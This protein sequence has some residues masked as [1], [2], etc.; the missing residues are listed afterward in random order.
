MTQEILKNCFNSLALSY[1]KKNKTD[2]KTARLAVSKLIRVNQSKK[3]WMGRSITNFD[4]SLFYLKD[5][6]EIYELRK[7]HNRK[8]NKTVSTYVDIEKFKDSLRKVKI[9]YNF[10]QEKIK[11]PVITYKLFN[12]AKEVYN[13]LLIGKN[14][15]IHVIAEQHKEGKFLYT[16]S[17]TIKG[18]VNPKFLTK[19]KELVFTDIAGVATAIDL[20][21]KDDFRECLYINNKNINIFKGYIHIPTK[22]H[23]KSIDEIK[24]L[25]RKREDLKASK[26]LKNDL[27]KKIKEASS[28]IIVTRKDSLKAGNC[29][30]GTDNFISKYLENKESVK[31]SK[32]YEISKIKEMDEDVKE[33]LKSVISLKEKEI[34]NTL[35]NLDTLLKI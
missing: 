24:E 4:K 6:G 23:G 26:K 10:P 30:S 29:S 5:L 3:D 11:Y 13:K 18:Y 16:D 2:L 14:T 20:K 1:A 22:T 31:L 27:A 33:R 32:L 15:D 28:E 7:A 9:T 21:S 25:L 35:T 19:S 34:N 12:T 8:L 17:Y